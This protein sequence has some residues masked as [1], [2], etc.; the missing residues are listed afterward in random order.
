MSGSKMNKLQSL[1]KVEDCGF[2]VYQRIS[3][4]KQQPFPFV[5]TTVEMGISGVDSFT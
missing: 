1:Q 2:F 5:P 4:P 3:C